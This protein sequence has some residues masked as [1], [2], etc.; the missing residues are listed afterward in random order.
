MLHTDVDD[1]PRVDP[2]DIRDLAGGLVFLALLGLGLYIN[3][4]AG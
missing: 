3:V 2:R 1:R 4:L